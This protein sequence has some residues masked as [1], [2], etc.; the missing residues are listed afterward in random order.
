[1]RRLRL[2]SESFGSGARLA[3]AFFEGLGLGALLLAL[4]RVGYAVSCAYCRWVG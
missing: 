1:M 4:L 3:L 2:F